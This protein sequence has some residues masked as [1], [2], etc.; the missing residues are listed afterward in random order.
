MGKNAD[1]SI[2]LITDESI[3]RI[4]LSASGSA[5]DYD[6]SYANDLLNNYFYLKLEDNNLIVNQTWCSEPTEN[7]TSAR[8]NCTNNLSTTL[9]KVG[10]ISL[11]GWNLSGEK[12]FNHFVLQ[13]HFF[14]IFKSLSCFMVEFSSLKTYKFM[15]LFR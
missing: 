5:F 10:V 1:G 15:L 7:N 14:L 8:T 11:D 4:S 9:S 2:R 3:T 12:L 13:L 6:N